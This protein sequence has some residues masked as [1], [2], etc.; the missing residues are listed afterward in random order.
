MFRVMFSDLKRLTETVQW[1]TMRDQRLNANRPT[2][3]QRDAFLKGP[4]DGEAA[5]DTQIF[6]EYIVG[7]EAGAGLTRRNAK[8]P[9]FA[10]GAGVAKCL[11]QNRGYAADIDHDVVARWGQCFEALLLLIVG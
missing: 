7:N 11:L 5:D 10:T 9:D 3:D 8:H 4:V 6:A 1:Q 2:L